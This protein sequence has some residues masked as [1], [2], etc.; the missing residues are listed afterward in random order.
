MGAE[1]EPDDAKQTPPIPRLCRYLSERS[2]QPTVAVEGATHIVSYLN[3]AF[4]RLVGRERKDLIGRP[5]AEAV[6]EGDGN[7]C[8]ALLDR[9]FRTGIPENLAEQEHHHTQPRPA[10]WSYSAWAILGE[11]GRPAGVMIQVTDAT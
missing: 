2:P 8:L 11:D 3:P 6:P 10:Y 7:G 1:L 9:V 5:F 4:A